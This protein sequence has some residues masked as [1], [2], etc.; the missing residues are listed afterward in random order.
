[1]VNRAG[2]IQHSFQARQTIKQHLA[3]LFVGS[4]AKLIAA[5]LKNND[6]VLVL[7][8][9]PRMLGAL[10]KKLPAKTLARLGAKVARDLVDAPKTSLAEH[11][12]EAVREALR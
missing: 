9:S 2:G 5:R 11:V 12:R 8:A 7:V 10:T 1:M 4:I 6:D 3:E